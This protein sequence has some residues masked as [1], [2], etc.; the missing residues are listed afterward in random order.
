MEFPTSVAEASIYSTIV[1]ETAACC[2]S[3]RCPSTMSK[4]TYLTEKAWK[5]NLWRAIKWKGRPPPL[6]V[7][8]NNV[9]PGQT[10]QQTSSSSAVYKLADNGEMTCSIYSKVFT[11][12]NSGCTITSIISKGCS[13]VKFE[14]FR[15]APKGKSRNTSDPSSP[16]LTKSTWIWLSGR[17]ARRI[18]TSSSFRIIT[19]SPSAFKVNLNEIDIDTTNSL[20]SLESLQSLCFIFRLKRR[21]KVVGNGQSAGLLRNF[22]VCR[23]TAT[24]KTAKIATV[25]RLE[26]TKLL[27]EKID[28]PVDLLSLRF[29]VQNPSKYYY[30]FS[31]Y[32]L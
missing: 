12:T 27:S 3:V 22:R 20:N 4:R 21:K 1:S 14:Q 26:L 25:F 2:L 11:K 31:K 24:M 17:P 30:L 19:W 32:C 28:L 6:L 9:F 5:K 13:G 10:D 16:T 7:I 8:C 29:F 18:R 15:P 23:I